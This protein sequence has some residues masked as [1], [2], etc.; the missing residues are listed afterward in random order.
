M[1]YESIDEIRRL[2]HFACRFSLLV[3]DGWMNRRRQVRLDE[4]EF[5][6][7]G[8]VSVTARVSRMPTLRAEPGGFR[9]HP[10]VFLSSANARVYE[11]SCNRGILI[12]VVR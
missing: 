6:C 10:P 4:G 9:A 3:Q 7:D 11:P 2:H 1:D 12:R 5:G 8:H